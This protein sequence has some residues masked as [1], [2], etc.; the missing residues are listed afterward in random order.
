MSDDDDPIRALSELQPSTSTRWHDPDEVRRIA[1]RR[2]RLRQAAIAGGVVVV[3][4]IAAVAIPH[5]AQHRARGFGH[6]ACR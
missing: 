3:I 5:G 2:P 6:R 1:R 4:T